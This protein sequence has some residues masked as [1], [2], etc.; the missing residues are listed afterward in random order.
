MDTA[1]LYAES[2]N[3][4]KQN[5]IVQKYI[6]KR[7]EDLK[8]YEKTGGKTYEGAWTN[9]MAAL[10]IRGE[11][12]SEMGLVQ[13]NKLRKFCNK[14]GADYRVE[15]T[16]RGGALAMME[17][18]AE[19]E[20][21]GEVAKETED[22]AQ[23][24]TEKENQA[25]SETETENEN[26]NEQETEQ[27]QERELPPPPFD[28][29][30][31]KPA[32]LSEADSFQAD[33]VKA[34]FTQLD[35]GG[36]G[37]LTGDGFGE[38]EKE[39][40]PFDHIIAQWL[41]ATAPEGIDNY[42][43]FV[44][45]WENE[46][47]VLKFR[48]PDGK[49]L[50]LAQAGARNLFDHLFVTREWASVYAATPKRGTL[51]SE[52]LDMVI[53]AEGAAPKMEKFV[54]GLVEYLVG[55]KNPRPTPRPPLR[56]AEFA[57][58]LRT[59]GASSEKL[60]TLSDTTVSSTGPRPDYIRLET[61]RDFE[62]MYWEARN[63]RHFN[64]V[65]GKMEPGN[66]VLVFANSQPEDK[67]KLWTLA[68]EGWGFGK[69]EDID[70]KKQDYPRLQDSEVTDPLEHDE[71]L[72][73]PMAEALAFD[74][75]GVIEQLA[76]NLAWEVSGRDVYAYSQYGR[77][78]LQKMREQLFHILV[79]VL[80]RVGGQINDAYHA[81]W[82]L[83]IAEITGDRSSAAEI[84]GDDDEGSSGGVEA[85]GGEGESISGLGSLADEYISALVEDMIVFLREAASIYN[86]SHPQHGA[87][88]SHEPAKENM[89][90]GIEDRRARFGKIQSYKAQGYG[91]YIASFL[92]R[93]E[94]ELKGLNWLFAAGE[95]LP[96]GPGRPWASA[97]W[98]QIHRVAEL[99]TFFHNANDGPA[100]SEN[101]KGGLLTKLVGWTI[102]SRSRGS[103]SEELKL[104]AYD[105]LHHHVLELRRMFRFVD[106]S[107]RGGEPILM[108]RGVHTC[109]GNAVEVPR[110]MCVHAVRDL[111]L[112]NQLG[113]K[114][115]A[116]PTSSL[117]KMVTVEHF[118]KGPF[119]GKPNLYDNPGVRSQEF[120]ED[121][122]W[123]KTWV[124]SDYGVVNFS[125]GF[126]TTADAEDKAAKKAA[127]DAAKQAASLAGTYGTPPRGCSVNYIA[128]SDTALRAR[129]L[130]TNV[131]PSAW[132]PGSEANTVINSGRPFFN[133]AEHPP[134][135]TPS[136]L[137]ARNALGNRWDEFRSVCFSVGRKDAG[138]AENQ[139]P[140]TT[141]R[142][143]TKER[144]E[145][146]S[147]CN[148]LSPQ[149]LQF[150]HAYLKPSVGKIRSMF[151]KISDT[152]KEGIPKGYAVWKGKEV[153]G[154]LLS[155]GGLS[156]P[157]QGEVEGLKVGNKNRHTPEAGAAA[158]YLTWRLPSPLKG[159]FV[160]K[161]T[162]TPRRRTGAKAKP[163]M[164]SF[165]LNNLRWIVGTGSGEDVF[166]F[167]RHGII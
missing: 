10:G 153:P 119:G 144:V 130:F 77:K 101:A 159:D 30:P 103:E 50:P 23:Q 141:T 40:I 6:D 98:E 46:M 82:G 138:V 38:L 20:R 155:L 136:E 146:E 162:F 47:N 131:R 118:E 13:L 97:V 75:A 12:I 94:S 27:E 126:S 18:E 32:R 120:P 54:P 70:R 134:V 21:E 43:D 133:D 89:K 22:E 34:V 24:E 105:R 7:E 51:L 125:V 117:Q 62:R 84:P 114:Q 109:K 110:D 11:D 108:P 78:Q 147:F 37:V 55:Q 1:T 128:Y 151:A 158:G 29:E 115:N 68:E 99:A 73:Q 111:F 15:S 79:G 26:E 93:N 102:G 4:Q 56:S 72:V 161:S 63:Q 57:L 91:S 58:W 87:S 65:T 83:S 31:K 44:Q 45:K 74:L 64:P 164:L 96:A 149:Q 148:D 122:E 25:Q 52:A 81:K 49:R 88:I 71:W 8:T 3:L 95:Q 106:A 145:V 139:H 19:Q 69:V 48:A 67:F 80:G 14:F 124:D 140:G 150:T 61:C 166:S 143:R 36:G 9:G 129:G 157:H 60:K 113:M 39:L 35:H 132:W 107:Q 165:Q 160:I 92:T 5:A 85:S 127:E 137:Q 42:T 16:A 66:L 86:T 163:T 142:R 59:K 112:R 135:S 41:A 152:Q 28:K 100:L 2:L 154:Q 53:G 121:L 17:E 104:L 33:F 123:K 156:S 116:R 167:C 76:R 90:Q